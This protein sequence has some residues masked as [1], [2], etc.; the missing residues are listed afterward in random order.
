MGLCSTFEHIA[1]MP[2]PC[3]HRPV[4]IGDPEYT[5]LVVDKNCQAQIECIILI[6]GWNNLPRT[7]KGFLV[8][9]SNARMT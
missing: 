2:H 3:K 5:T 6:I 9:K 7:T 1:T 8:L 4:Y